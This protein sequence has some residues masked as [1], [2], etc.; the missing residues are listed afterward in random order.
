[1][2]YDVI[3]TRFTNGFIFSPD[4]TRVLLIHKNRPDWM[5]GK[6]NGI[7]GKLEDGESMLQCIVR[8]IHEETGLDTAESEWVRLGDLG[9]DDWQMDVFTMRHTG[10]ESDARTMED[11]EVE[12]FDVAALPNTVMSNLPWL[13]ALAID[14]LSSDE[15]DTFSCQYNRK[16][17]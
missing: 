15:L 17:S 2:Y 9:S 14:K 3:M 8:E 5:K 12:W 1:M 4:L 16:K 6:L 10:K 13:I 7:G 11:E